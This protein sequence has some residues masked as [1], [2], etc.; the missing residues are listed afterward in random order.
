M[1]VVNASAVKTTIFIKALSMLKGQAWLTKK[2]APA[3]FCWTIIFLG[4]LG[5][6]LTCVKK[7]ATSSMKVFISRI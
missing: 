5:G 6:T 4:F 3:S 2:T 7:R 1:R